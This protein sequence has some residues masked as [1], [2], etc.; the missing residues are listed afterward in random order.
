M[1]LFENIRKCVTRR[2][3]LQRRLTKVFF[4]VK[5]CD[6]FK[7]CNIPSQL[8]ELLVYIAQ[9]GVTVTDLF[10]KPGN[11]QDIKKIILDLES[12]YFINW[13]DYSFYTLA[14]VAKRYL[15][16][17][18]G[19]IFGREAED[20]LL[21][22]LDSPDD[23]SR[24]ESMHSVIVS[25]PQPVQQLLSLLFGI[26]FRMIYHTE[27]NAMSVEA[28]A[29]SVAGS[30]FPNST[31]SPEKVERASKVMEYL[32]TGFASADLFS[33]EMIE[34]FT[35]ATKTSISRIEKF[36]YEFR[37]PKN[38][39]REKSVRLFMRLL[40]EESKKHNF[41]LIND[42]VSKETF[43]NAN[44]ATLYSPSS[45][46]SSIQNDDFGCP[47]KKPMIHHGM[48]CD[49]AS[50]SRMVVTTSD[51]NTQPNS[52]PVPV[53]NRRYAGASAQVT[54]REVESDNIPSTIDPMKDPVQ[55]LSEKHTCVTTN[56]LQ[57]Q[58]SMLERPVYPRQ[59]KLECDAE[60]N[61]AGSVLSHHPSNRVTG[62]TVEDPCKKSG[63]LGPSN[64][65]CFS[66]VKRRQLERLQKRSDWFLSPPAGLR[67]SGLMHLDPSTPK[68]P[69]HDTKEPSPTS[70]S[71]FK[72]H[73]TLHPPNLPT[74]ILAR[75]KSQ[76]LPSESGV[77]TNKNTQMILSTYPEPTNYMADDE[78]GRL[79]IVDPVRLWD[80]KFTCDSKLF[81][82]S[83]PACASS[84]N[85][86]THFNS[87]I[88]S[89]TSEE[90]ENY[91]EIETRYYVVQRYYGPEPRMRDALPA[92]HRI[93]L[94]AGTNPPSFSI[95][96]T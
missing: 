74:G 42:A 90:K 63:R 6:S 43:E 80:T 3:G 30:V 34:Y 20:Y 16:H 32:I 28:V 52:R 62:F 59:S 25:Q 58:T 36:K 84:P 9:D 2:H 60:F 27:V 7:S 85:P 12:G 15:I 24:I 87:E 94:T 29:K 68:L 71:S 53:V 10:R 57:R 93:A 26:W 66:S 75:S 70:V 54:A 41:H 49:S 81:H 64:A 65:V 23:Q 19:G 77:L 33:R 55:Q 31:T 51:C 78:I 13:R 4:N 45:R 83:P 5:L 17:L 73:T 37:F 35:T 92:I 14:N 76:R 69:P 86:S 22:L 50:N 48:L 82:V 47:A 61:Q 39:P 56:P 89:R 67:S 21:E 11:P 46:D 88:D 8:K 95:N 91:P 38:L 72:E 40:L 18:D 79:A 44:W 1:P 96:G